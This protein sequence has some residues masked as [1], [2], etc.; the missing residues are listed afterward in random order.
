[1]NKTS[2]QYG[3]TAVAEK[4][5]GSSLRRTFLH[6]PWCG[7]LETSRSFGALSEPHLVVIP[8]SRQKIARFDIGEKVAF[9][10]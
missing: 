9:T 10:P 7:G 2:A 4:V 5:Y 3:K 6:S 1:M 8:S